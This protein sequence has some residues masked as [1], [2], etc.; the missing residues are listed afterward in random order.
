MKK[1]ILVKIGGSLITDKSKPF[2]LK[3]KAL[4]IICQEIKS[5]QEKT[6]KLL[7]IGHGA[8]SFGHLPAKK[9]RVAEGI[10]NK[11]SLRGIAETQAVA[12]KLNKIV[13]EKLIETGL[14]AVSISPFSCYLAR[15]GE[16]SK[17]FLGP[18]KKLL[19]LRMLPVLYGDVVLDSRKGCCILSTEKVLGGLAIVLKKQGFLIEKII[20]CGKTNGVLDDKGQTISLIT[21]NNFGKYKNLIGHSEG[22]DVTGGMIHKVRQALK[23]AENGISSLII[24]GIQNSV[25]S[26]A[27]LGKK[28]LGTE[29]R[30]TA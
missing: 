22:V 14:S 24:D 13:V 6:D 23:L 17:I 21:A 28:V 10:I 16:V 12:A 15:N 25:L 3:P 9:Y 19:R 18:I 27:V 20:Y 8:G 4:E 30:L 2:S 1:I 29:I 7:I 11:K 26:R 5:V